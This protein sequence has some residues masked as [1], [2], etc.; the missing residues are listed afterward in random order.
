METVYDCEAEWLAE[1][2]TWT[3]KAIPCAAVSGVP[4]I[5]TVFVVLVLIAT[6]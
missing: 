1:S 5:I 3:V 2:V 4:E 6:L